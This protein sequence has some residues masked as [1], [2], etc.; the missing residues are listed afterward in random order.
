MKGVHCIYLNSIN[1]D[2]MAML[3]IGLQCSLGGEGGGSVG[4]RLVP[5]TMHRHLM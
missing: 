4:R 1:V 5:S 3:T 2:P